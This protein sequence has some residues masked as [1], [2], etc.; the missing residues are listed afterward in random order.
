MGLDKGGIMKKSLLGLMLG[1]VLCFGADQEA[2]A[3]G[4][5]KPKN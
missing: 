1:I 2:L 3:D 4:K 5:K